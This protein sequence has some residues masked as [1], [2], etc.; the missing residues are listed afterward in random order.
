MKKTIQKMLLQIIFI[1]LCIVAFL[2]VT[3]RSFIY[4]PSSA[5]PDATQFDNIEEIEVTTVDNLTLTGWF[6]KPTNEKYTIVIFH[7]NASNHIGSYYTL[8]PY[9]EQGY[10]FLSIGYR[11]YNGNVGKP[12]EEG[13]YK[14]ARAF[15]NGLIETGISQ[16][17]VILYGQSI[18]TG[19][20]VQ[21]AT[22]FPNVKAVILESPYTSLPDVAAKTYFFVP[23]HFLMKDKF[24]SYSKIKNMKSP[25]F[26]LQGKNDQTIDPQLGERLFDAAN[27][28]KYLFQFQGHGH[29][30]L[31]FVKMAEKVIA[32][33]QKL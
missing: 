23:V 25:L 22:E 18:G 31:P 15:I 17:K 1:Y 20:A 11:G 16:E 19:V 6:K 8:Q 26:I 14:D 27:E 3:Q 13:F 2:Y 5:K 10:G 32:S 4:F 28:P 30:D 12:S 33:L 9:I 24:D 21:M 7:G 29:N